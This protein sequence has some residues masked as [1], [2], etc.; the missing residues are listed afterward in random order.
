MWIYFSF[1]W[2]AAPPEIYTAVWFE[3]AYDRYNLPAQLRIRLEA[4][5]EEDEE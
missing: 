4:F 3:Y 2:V 5:T 1:G